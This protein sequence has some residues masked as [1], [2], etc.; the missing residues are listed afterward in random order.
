MP[1]FLFVANDVI[2]PRMAGPGIRAWEMARAL[3][4]HGVDVTLA[5]PG[6]ELVDPPFPTVAYDTRGDTLRVAA[7]AADVIL[8]Q[9]LVLAHYPFLAALDTP[10]V[11]DLYDPFVL[12]NL[13]ARAGEQSSGRA[14][15]HASDL[16]VLNAQIERGDFF[17]CASETQRDYWLGMLTALGRVNPATYTA[18]PS[19]R[20]LIDVVPFGVPAESPEC[21]APMLK[22]VVD[23]IAPGD[24]VLLWGG[25]IWNWFDPLTL[26]RAVAEVARERP[27]VRLFFLSAAPPPSLYTPQ[28]SMAQRAEALAR[29]LDV[30]DRVVFFN[31]T[32]V[33]Y[34]DR[35]S[36]LLEADVG[37]SCHLPHLE[38]RFAFRT[39]LLDCIWASLP[40]LVT[41]GDVLADLVA[42]AELGRVVPP[43]DS[44]AVVAAIHA[45]M[46]ADGGRA[47][48]AERFAAVRAGMTWP[49]VV[50]PLAA[51][52]RAPHAAP[53]RPAGTT[54]T[55]H[56]A[57]TPIR[58]LPARVV[59]VL[60]EGGPLLLLE[61]VAR[62]LRW[63]R[64]PRG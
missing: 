46:D 60:H 21:G 30:L 42:R 43:E 37:A 18:D 62:Y 7:A 5:A 39:R 28:R 9:G 50:G 55:R 10:L 64:R 33:P 44:A 23:G 29:D 61:E 19:G 49:T 58:A 47:G 41:S 1:R 38:T 52:A 2:G 22:G 20:Q 56:V 32:W 13:Q 15:H 48:Y 14:R 31:R 11:V 27:N 17:I 16:A 53:D 6:I 34:A 59:E 45:L 63:L 3:V 12:E 51:F 57:T 36:Y 40:M 26:I 54:V 25:G 8:V 24:F 35:A 4:G